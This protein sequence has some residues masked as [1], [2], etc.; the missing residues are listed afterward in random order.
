MRISRKERE[1][2]SARLNELGIVPQYHAHHFRLKRDAW[3]QLKDSK[4]WYFFRSQKGT[5]LETSPLLPQTQ[6]NQG[7]FILSYH[8]KWEKKLIPIYDYVFYFS[9]L[10][11]NV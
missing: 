4:T 5:N 3:G 6:L 2:R 9:S 11:K 8:P 1:N 7:S 10:E